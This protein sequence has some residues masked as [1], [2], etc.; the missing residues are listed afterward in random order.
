MNK[1]LVLCGRGSRTNLHRGNIFWLQE[2]AKLQKIYL[3][4]SKEGKKFI[5]QELIERIRRTG[6]RFLEAVTHV[7]GSFS[8]RE[9][10]D[11]K[12]LLKKAGQ[13]LRETN[14]PMFYRSKRER[15]RKQGRSN[16]TPW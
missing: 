1:F 14:D 16:S 10:T 7:D 9:V 8:Y 15:Y 3:A 13:T 11:R 5:S 6:G 12:K 2:K 4:A